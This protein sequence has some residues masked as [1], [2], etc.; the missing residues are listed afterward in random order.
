LTTEADNKII[1][2][3]KMLDYTCLL[4]GIIHWWYVEDQ[5]K[6]KIDTIRKKNEEG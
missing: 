2:F 1:S 4:Y 6:K 5:L 3:K